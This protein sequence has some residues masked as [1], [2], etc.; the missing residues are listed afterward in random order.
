MSSRCRDFIAARNCCQKFAWQLVKRSIDE[1][2]ILPWLFWEIRIM[3]IMS[4]ADIPNLRNPDGCARFDQARLVS[5]QVFALRLFSAVIPANAN[6]CSG[7]TWSHENRHSQFS[8]GCPG[9]F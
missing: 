8:S 9:I 4:N 7:R 5:S 2:E 6:V 1:L 3:Y